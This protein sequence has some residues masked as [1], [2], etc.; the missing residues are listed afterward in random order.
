[1]FVIIKEMVKDEA[2]YKFI[3][4]VKEMYLVSS[5]LPKKLEYTG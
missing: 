2:P 1:M 5:E 3:N 4:E